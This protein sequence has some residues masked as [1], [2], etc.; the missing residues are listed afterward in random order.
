MKQNYIRIFILYFLI[1]C[2]NVC[3]VFRGPGCEGEPG[4]PGLH[5]GVHLQGSRP[6]DSGRKL[7]RQ[8]TPGGSI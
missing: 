3:S 4:E 2:F 5:E 8:T 7:A 1:H 6:G